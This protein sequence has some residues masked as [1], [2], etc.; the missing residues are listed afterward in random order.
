MQVAF[1]RFGVWVGLAGLCPL[2]V[3]G[4]AKTAV[5]P[6]GNEPLVVVKSETVYRMAADG[7]GEKTRTVIA[8]I[9]SE[10]GLKE[11]GVLAMPFAAKS[12][13]V[14]WIYA[15]VRHTD[16]TVTET[17]VN[18]ALEVA[19]QVTREAPFYSDLKQMQ[20]PL[21]D[22]RVGDTLEW[23]AKEIRT[24]AEA[25]NEFW[26]QES[27][28]PNVVILNE[29]VELD[30]PKGV[31][32]NAWSPGQ[33]P[34]EAE[35]GDRRT[36]RWTY[37]QLKPTVGAEA[38]AA[39]EADKKRVRT[40]DEE[41]DE[42]EG[43]LPDVAWTTFKS[44]AEVGAWYQGLEGDRMVPDAEVKAKVAQLTA[45]KTTGREKAQAVYAYV[46]TQIHYIGVSF[47]IGRYQ[48]HS[49][50]DVLGNQYGDCKD[51]HT[52]LA[53]M[54]EAIGLHPDAVLIGAGIRFNEA[55]PSPGSFN[56]LI[57]RVTLDGK[58]VWLDTT[59]EVA[60]FGMLMYAIRDRKALAI[61]ETG[62]ATVERTPARPPFPAVQTM[63]A[64][65]TLDKDGIS[66][67]K[68]TLTSR[69]DDE[70]VIRSV[71]RSLSPAQYD[72]LAQQ[73]CAG[74][75]Y[76]GTASHMDVSR[77]E[78]TTEPVKLS[79]D[80]K[81]EK[82]GDWA[83]YRTIPQLS[84]VTLPR[85]DPKNPPI[86][87]ISLGVPRVELSKSA[88]TLPE[89]WGVEFPEAVHAKSKW[90][91]YDETYRFEKGTMYA[92]RRIEVLAERVPL[93][94]WKEYSKFAEQA[95]LG[96][97]Q[98]IQLTRPKATTD[99]GSGKSEVTIGKDDDASSEADT[100][101]ETVQQLVEEVLA[102]FQKPDV[103]AAGPLLDKVKAKN[104]TQLGLWSMYGYLAFRN[105]DLAG[106]IKDYQKELELH[107][108]ATQTY[109]ALVQA[110]LALKQRDEAKA[111][112]RQWAAADPVNAIPTLQLGQMQIDDGQPLE[113]VKTAEVA[114]A[115]TPESEK[116]DER[117]ELLLGRAQL[118][119]G[120]KDKGHATLLALAKSTDD[121]GM[122]N[123]AA[124]ELADAGL[125]LLMAEQ[126]TRTALDRM[127]EET[128]TWT[129][130]EA[131]TTLKQKTSLLQAT[132]D[133]MGWIYFRE[134]KTEAAEQYVRASWLGRQSE[135]VGK[136]L[137]EIDEAK[138][139]KA[140]AV[141][142]YLLALETVAKYDVMG[143]HR[144]AGPMEKDLNA[145]VDAL[146]STGVK[147]N[148][149]ESALQTMRM[150]PI[151][152][153]AG[154]NGVGE[155]KI[156]VSASGISRVEPSNGKLLAGGEERL[157]KTKLPGFVP[158]GS[159]GQLA[160]TVLLNCHSGVCELVLEP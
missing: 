14:E 11:V 116:R 63:E 6:Y 139:E 150:I 33:T 75:G 45:G 81:R 98:Y 140:E 105:G 32:V 159:N 74:M 12:E 40:A 52:L 35:S 124:Y 148:I 97:E 89:G 142:D 114:L 96:N 135:E 157:K 27:F 155:Y 101:T 100:G 123:D 103:S 118:R 130:D 26:G 144:E 49:A 73:I 111:S 147:A 86:E 60:P 149:P 47:G 17:P 92:E 132:W 108:G 34:V 44:W 61:P 64:V 30:A 59:A 129:L 71:V 2:G 39:K 18:S 13:H 115:A 143:V 3:P 128:R 107:P 29:T 57:T 83:N 56:H 66:N 58:P 51:K 136:H 48:P 125:E 88:M 36:W 54:L 138:G 69:G 84:P 154:L 133:T 62:V 8:R 146:R 90:A 20:L 158:E 141:K 53:S 95:D 76:G 137:G 72:A 80:Y 43:K 122:M 70:I 104:P 131:P 41:V 153:A 145:R 55:V 10:A 16:G 68:I 87:S 112:L 99:K 7:T 23:Q 152:P 5:D 24:V 65:G 78:D 110:Q 1:L 9:Q 15:R 119:A 127:E 19:E 126:T 93:A 134:G 121:A 82:A 91:T 21:K 79:F 151:G 109:P 77:V 38:D 106:A 67:S 22:L 37:T 4:Q 102:A 160:F 31:Y 46:A 120:L 85:P 28:T 156:L 50:A 42:R 113:A 94:E 117:V 25:P